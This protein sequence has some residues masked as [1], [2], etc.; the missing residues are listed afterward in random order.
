MPILYKKRAERRVT[1]QKNNTQEEPEELEKDM[2][3]QK[4]NLKV[5]LEVMK[6][7]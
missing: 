5:I 1:R 3:M 4:R 7:D 6:T 2:K